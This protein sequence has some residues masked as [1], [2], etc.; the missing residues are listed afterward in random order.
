MDFSSASGTEDPWAAAMKRGDFETAWRINDAILHD[1]IQS[2]VDCREWPR[3][4]QFVWRG[5]SLRD[6]RVLVR[7]Y[8]GLGDTIQF[9]RLLTPLAAIAREVVVWAQPPL[10][11]LISTIDGVAAVLPLNDGAPPVGFEADIEIME[12]AYALRVSSDS[13]PGRVPYLFP[14]TPIHPLDKGQF[15]TVGLVWAAGDW[16]PGRSVPAHLFTRLLDITGVRFVSLQRGSPQHERSM[17][18]IDDFSSDDV[19]VTAARLKQLDLLITVDSM[20]AHLAGAL[21]VRVWTLLQ[22]G[23]D[24]RWMNTGER[25]VWYPTMRLCRQPRA[26]AWEPVLNEVRAALCAFSAHPDKY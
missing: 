13:M 26:G 5:G 12:L 7:C 6:K 11:K 25:S 19:D 2:A 14:R 20:P 9:A 17:L 24:W 4:L 10:L 3:H 21:G 16:N 23:C 1:R 15:L 8:H 22:L 18:G